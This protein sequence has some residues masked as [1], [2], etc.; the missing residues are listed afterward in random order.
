MEFHP[1][2]FALIAYGVAAVIAACVAFIVKAIALIVQG[3]KGAADGGAQP[4]SK[5]GSN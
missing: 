3:K 5:G 1:L 4:E 2:V